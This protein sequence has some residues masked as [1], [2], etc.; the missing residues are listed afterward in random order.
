MDRAES[1][2]RD[3]GGREKKTGGGTKETSRGRET[4]KRGSGE[5]DEGRGGMTEAKRD[6]RH[7]LSGS[8]LTGGCHIGVA[9][10]LAEEGKSRTVGVSSI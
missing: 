4:T 9:K 7:L 3:K 1:K 2:K 8:R 10:K 6:R 5:A